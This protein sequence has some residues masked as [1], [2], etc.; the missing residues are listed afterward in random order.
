[1]YIVPVSIYYV[2][3]DLHG[4]EQALQRVMTLADSA[5][6]DAILF[7]GDLGIRN[8]GVAYQLR[9]RNRPFL[10]VRGNCDSPWDFQDADLPVPPLYSSHRFGNWEIFMTHGD[11]FSGPQDVGLK[12]A[13][14]QIVI[15]GHTHVPMLKRE[16]NTICLNP[17]S[18]SLPRGGFNPTFAV[19][20]GSKIEIKEI[21]TLKKVFQLAF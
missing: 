17:G 7:S 16:G 10:C 3:S 20:D 21:F 9:L 8:P 6:A 19:I 15:S 2:L 18:A 1:M 13:E 14:K 11:R 5:D 4:D 12:S